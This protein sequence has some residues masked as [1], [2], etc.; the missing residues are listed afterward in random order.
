MPLS[1]AIETLLYVLRCWRLLK[2]ARFG[3]WRLKAVTTRMPVMFSARF[4]ETC[5]HPS[6]ATCCMAPALDL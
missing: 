2:T 5:V 4:V 3:S 1:R 6:R